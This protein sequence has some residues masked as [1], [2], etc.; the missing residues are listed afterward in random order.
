MEAGKKG[1]NSLPNSSNKITTQKKNVSIKRNYEVEKRYVIYGMKKWSKKTRNNG[2][3][4]T[5]INV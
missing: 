2:K 1:R 5:M 4:E 3:Y